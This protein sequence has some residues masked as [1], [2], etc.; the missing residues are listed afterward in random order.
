M[1]NL[2]KESRNQLFG[3]IPK[4]IPPRHDL[5]K[6]S[7]NQLLRLILKLIPPRQDLEKESKNQ[8]FRMVPLS[9]CLVGWMAGWL[10]TTGCEL[11]VGLNFSNLLEIRERHGNLRGV[12][13]Y[14]SVTCWY[15]PIRAKYVRL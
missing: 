2:E 6:E 11:K 4:L 15:G 12:L 8:L 5:E 7:R 1:K 13:N 10:R 3:L 14:G 9:V